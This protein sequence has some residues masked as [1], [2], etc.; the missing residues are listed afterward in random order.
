[1]GIE[2]Q[3]ASPEPAVFRPWLGFRV[4]L[5]LAATCLSFVLF[6]LLP[7]HAGVWVVLW[8]LVALMAIVIAYGMYVM[9]STKYRIVDGV[10]HVHEGGLSRRIELDTISLVRLKGAMFRGRLCGLGTGVYIH[11]KI[12]VRHRD[13]RLFVTPRDVD[14]FLAAIGAR[15]NGPGDVEIGVLDKQRG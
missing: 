5:L 7:L 3:S 1:M 8:A 13:R 15:R 9:L 12:G 11:Y 14:A 2:A 10:L 4:C 6:T